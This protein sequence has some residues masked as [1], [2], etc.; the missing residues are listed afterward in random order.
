[1]I[2]QFE[3]T[4]RD[5]AKSWKMRLNGFVDGSFKL[6]FWVKVHIMSKYEGC[7]EYI[8]S[9]ASITFQKIKSCYKAEN[10]DMTEDYIWKVQ[11]SYTL[12]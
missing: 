10:Y 5:T 8:P 4:Y 6:K 9:S 3:L 1:M 12:W 2:F 7:F 11:N